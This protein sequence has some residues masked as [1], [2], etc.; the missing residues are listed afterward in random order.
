[1]ADKQK[2]SFKL[3]QVSAYRVDKSTKIAKFVEG[4][5]LETGKTITF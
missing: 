3:I 2:F 4:I 1:M 5:D